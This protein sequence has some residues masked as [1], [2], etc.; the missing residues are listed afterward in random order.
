ML[1]EHHTRLYDTV[2]LQDS[3]SEE[4]IP[5]H[6][7]FQVTILRLVRAHER[8]TQRWRIQ[9]T[10]SNQEQLRGFHSFQPYRRLKDP[11]SKVNKF[12]RT[13]FSES[14]SKHSRCVSAVPETQGS[15]F[16]SE[17]VHPYRILRISF[18]TFTL[19]FLLVSS[20]LKS[21]CTHHQRL[22]SKSISE[23]GHSNRRAR[24]ISRERHLRSKI[25]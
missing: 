15:S 11:L 6:P 5:P 22:S 12:T 25:R 4:R 16:Q 7:I 10:Q 17:Q 14:L 20:N 19:Y 21:L 2:A 9:R 8:N 13:G 24:R 18:Q 23:V 3:S 1:G